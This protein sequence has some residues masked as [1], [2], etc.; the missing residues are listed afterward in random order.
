MD[1]PYDLP[2]PTEC[3]KSDAV[4]VLS[5]ASGGLAGF[6]CSLDQLLLCEQAGANLLEVETRQRGDD[7]S[8]PAYIAYSCS[9]D[10]WSLTHREAGTIIIPI[11]Q[12]RKQSHS[13]F[14][15]PLPKSS[16]PCT[17]WLLPACQLLRP[18]ALQTTF[19]RTLHT[20]NWA[21]SLLLRAFAHA[22][23][24]AW[25]ESAPSLSSYLKVSSSRKPSLPHCT[26]TVTYFPIHSKPLT[27]LTT[28]YNLVFICMAMWAC[29]SCP[30]DSWT[31]GTVMITSPLRPRTQ[32]SSSR[33]YLAQSSSTLTHW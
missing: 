1:W 22:V 7:C 25:T 20:L 32:R 30:V 13:W 21:W 28:I 17:I 26:S 23:P 24:S 4:S 6:S 9:T 2:G 10:H 27:A 15:N 8:R 18:C 5:P 33:K 19:L 16:K 14:P 12:M 29:P 31:V 3:N 11:L